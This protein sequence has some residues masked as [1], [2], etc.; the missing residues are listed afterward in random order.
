MS[1]ESLLKKHGWSHWY[2]DAHWVHQDIFKFFDKERNFYYG[3]DHTNFQ[4]TT[5]EAF[6][7][8]KK[9]QIK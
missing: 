8:C 7:L 3:T 9:Y 5:D 2:N 6:N 4:L 1:K